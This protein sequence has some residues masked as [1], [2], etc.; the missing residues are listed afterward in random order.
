MHNGIDFKSFSFFSQQKTPPIDE[1]LLN[2]LTENHMI[3]TKA[4]PI[5]TNVEPLGSIKEYGWIN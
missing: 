5:S 3:P 2:H 4:K 1:H